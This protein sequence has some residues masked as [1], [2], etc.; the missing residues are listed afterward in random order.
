MRFVNLSINN[1]DNLCMYGRNRDNRELFSDCQWNVS[2][3]QWNV[4]WNN[5]LKQLELKCCIIDI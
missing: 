1:E 5:T 4:I 2:D 3:C